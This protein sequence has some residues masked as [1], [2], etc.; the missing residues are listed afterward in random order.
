MAYWLVSQQPVVY[1]ASARLLVG[2]GIDSPNPDIAALRTG[3]QLMQT[4]AELT[5]TTPFLQS[6]IDEL[7][8]NLSPKDLSAM[9]DVKTN[10]ETQILSINV[11]SGNAS[12]AV[13][14][15]NTAAKALV[16]QSPS[17]EGSQ[18]AKMREQTLDQIARIEQIISSS[19]STIK[20][21]EIDLQN[22]TDVNKQRVITEQLTEERKRQSDAL[23]SITLLN[24][25]LQSTPTNQ[26]KIIEA[27]LSADQVLSQLRLKVLIASLAGLLLGLLVV[28]GYEFID[29]T[30]HTPEEILEQT[31]LPV[32]SVIARHRSLHGSGPA[33]LVVEA[34][35]E[36]SAAEN[37]RMLGTKLLSKFK[38]RSSPF[39][40]ISDQ[41]DNTTDKLSSAN[42]NGALHSILV[43]SS[44]R[45]DDTSEVVTNLAVVLAQTGNR[46]ILVDANLHHPTIGEIFGIESRSSLT[47]LLTNPLKEAELATVSW[48]TNLSILTSGSETS[49]PF[50][51][52]ASTRMAELIHDFE[53]KADIVIIA[54]EP[55]LSFASSLTLASRVDGVIVV[56]CSGRT[57][58]VML[59]DLVESLRSL[60]INLLGTVLEQNGP[61]SKSPGLTR[62]ANVKVEKVRIDSGIANTV[63]YE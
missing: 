38:A 59:G 49:N 63:H 54:A 27:A 29:D 4:Y 53:K 58:R 10:Q 16:N 43:G 7:R 25:S 33:R 52:L 17:G 46:V 51:L 9:M 40:V 36:S 26:V 11:T 44:Q 8:I 31:N 57:R 42:D 1:S 24:E 62:K 15:A 3:G 35:P 56:A 61:T 6:I 50:E 39:N 12:Q 5:Q 30:I 18:S 28:L 20:T 41:A 22:E 21:L 60:D 14:I 48:E 2:P 32:L 19:E 45:S 34:L 55:L 37:Y 23:N 47:D 13:A